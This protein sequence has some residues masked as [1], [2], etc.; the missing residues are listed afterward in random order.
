MARFGICDQD[1]CF[2][3]IAHLSTINR[4]G[5]NLDCWAAALDLEEKH[6]CGHT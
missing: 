4:S 1:N 5:I 3:Y 6:A 2:W